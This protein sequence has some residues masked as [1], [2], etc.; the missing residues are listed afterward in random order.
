[1]QAAAVQ[2]GAAGVGVTMGMMFNNAITEAR[3][4]QGRRL[5]QLKRH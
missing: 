1:M 3:V 4:G 2:G 5:M